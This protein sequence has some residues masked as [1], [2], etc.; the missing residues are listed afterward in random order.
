MIS[1]SSPALSIAERGPKRFEGRKLGI[2]LTDGF[3]AAVLKK[4]QR[5][6]TAEK[7][8]FEI[9]APSVGGAEAADGSKVDA[10]QMIDGAPSVLYDAVVLL[11][12]AAGATD[13]LKELT[14]RDFV[15]GCVRSLQVYWLHQSD[16]GVV[17][18]SRNSR[19]PR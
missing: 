1:S 7:A 13:L 19:C 9:I 2:L 5:A 15:A 11:P 8:T 18:E 3:D 6:I 4:L 17:R 12:S 14:A 16:I 10:N